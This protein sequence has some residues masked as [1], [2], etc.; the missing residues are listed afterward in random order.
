RRR[1]LDDSPARLPLARQEARLALEAARLDHVEG[2]IEPHRPLPQTL[3]GLALEDRQVS[4]GQMAHQVGCAE[5]QGPVED[6]HRQEKRILLPSW[7][8]TGPVLQSSSSGSTYRS[9]GA[10]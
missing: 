8:R 1:E 3:G 4:A 2:G 5:D 9:L 10:S 7:D 6:L